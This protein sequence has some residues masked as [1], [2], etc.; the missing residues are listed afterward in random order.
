MKS[1]SLH[2]TQCHGLGFQPS[3]VKKRAGPE[4]EALPVGL[5]G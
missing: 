5:V 2:L 3:C 4:T 1:L